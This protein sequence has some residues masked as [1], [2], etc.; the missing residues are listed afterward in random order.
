M[1]YG[2]GGRKG[3]FFSINRLFL[4]LSLSQ[5]NQTNLGGG[6]SNIFYFHPETLGKMIP[7]LTVAY[8][9]QWVETQPPTRNPVSGIADF[10][11]PRRPLIFFGKGLLL[12]CGSVSLL[13]VLL[14][15]E[16]PGPNHRFGCFLKPCKSWDKLYQPQLVI[17]G[18][19][20]STVSEVVIVILEYL[21]RNNVIH[22]YPIVYTER[23]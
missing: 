5:N 20:P 17:A 22:P 14:M 15:A 1:V 6:N 9:F 18:F 2:S 21:A 4:K 10:K 8:F 19:L 7:N 16:I 23:F 3:C 13:E 12:G 11:V